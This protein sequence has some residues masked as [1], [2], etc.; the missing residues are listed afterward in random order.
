MSSLARSNEEKDPETKS[1]TGPSSPISDRKCPPIFF[2]EFTPANR[3]PSS[4]P[5]KKRIKD[6][7]SIDSSYSLP[8]TPSGFFDITPNV[9]VQKK[10]SS[11]STTRDMEV[12]RF[13][14]P[15]KDLSTNT[16]SKT[17]I[18]AKSIENRASFPSGRDDAKKLAFSPANVRNPNKP[19]NATVHHNSSRNETRLVGPT[20]EQPMFLL[21]RQSPIASK[22]SND[23]SRSLERS[24]ASLDHKNTYMGLMRQQLEFFEISQ[25]EV[26][27]CKTKNVS[28]HV[29]QVALRCKHCTCVSIELRQ[30]G[31]MI[32]A[33]ELNSLYKH[34]FHGKNVHIEE[35]CP[36][37]EDAT[38][39]QLKALR[40][41]RGATDAQDQ[42]Y[43]SSMAKKEGVV[44]TRAGLRFKSSLLIAKNSK[45]VLK[46]AKNAAPSK[47]K[48]RRRVFDRK[49]PPPIELKSDDAKKPASMVDH[50]QDKTTAWLESMSVWHIRFQEF[51]YFKIK[52]GHGKW[53]KFLADTT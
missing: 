9:A 27:F 16:P 3:R 52:N 32:V 14:M 23:Y 47:K 2:D 24:N 20:R 48:K 18:K 38:Q 43:W 46:N 25:E 42:F 40:Q 33:M 26:A 50:P 44:E 13:R 28:V 30:R 21:P 39:D 29:G 22:A 49:K 5:L 31:S 17:Y 12:P 37:V 8:F 36:F 15:M 41:L 19:Q 34:F 10:E 7:C 53:Y 11:S 6:R 1:G 51:V 35:L 45:L 4:G